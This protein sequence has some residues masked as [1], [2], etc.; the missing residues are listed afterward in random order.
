MDSKNYQN[1]KLT[2]TQLNY[3][4]HCKRQLWLFTHQIICEQESDAVFLGKVIHE[5]SYERER[6]E[7]EID[8][9]KLDFLDVRD[10]VLHEVKKSDKWSDAHEWQVL[11]YLYVLKQKGVIGLRGELNYPTIRRTISVDLTPEKEQRL[12]KKLADIRRIIQLSI[13]PDI[14]VKKSVCRKCSYFELCY[15]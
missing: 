8:N 2:G 6:K 11:Y 5:T 7:V 1:S 10:G 15:V 3:Y 13:P 9:I 12:E 14:S 4:F